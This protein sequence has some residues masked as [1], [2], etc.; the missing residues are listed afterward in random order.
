MYWNILLL[1]TC[2]CRR[3]IALSRLIV[4]D[5]LSCP[6]T[7]APYSLFCMR[8]MHW[9]CRCW[10]CSNLAFFC[11]CR[12][13]Y[14]VNLFHIDDRVLKVIQRWFIFSVGAL[15]VFDQSFFLYFCPQFLMDDLLINFGDRRR[16]SDCS[17]LLKLWVVFYFFLL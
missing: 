9:H 1:L 4:L 12:P 5:L 17:D 13:V 6:T 16:Y 7:S 15:I 2:L 10:S 14:L 8:Q 11:F 3:V